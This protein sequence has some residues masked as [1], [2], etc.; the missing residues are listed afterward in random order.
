MEFLNLN[1]NK[2]RRERKILVKKKLR[3]KNFAEVTDSLETRNKI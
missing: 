3:M 1:K 2:E